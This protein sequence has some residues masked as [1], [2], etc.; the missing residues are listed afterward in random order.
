MSATG[1]SNLTDNTATGDETLTGGIQYEQPNDNGILVKKDDGLS[2]LYKS[3]DHLFFNNQ[4]LTG[5]AASAANSV[6]FDTDSNNPYSI[7]D[8][9]DGERLTQVKF[10]DQTTKGNITFS[11]DSFNFDKNIISPNVDATNKTDIAGKVNKSG[12]TMSGTLD[13]DSNPIKLGFTST[14]N[15]YNPVLYIGDND[16]SSHPY[17]EYNGSSGGLL[18]LVLGGN[19]GYFAVRS[20]SGASNDILRAD[21]NTITTNKPLIATDEIVMNGN[22]IELSN[23]NN[24]T[25]EYSNPTLNVSV[26]GN[27]HNISLNGPSQAGAI[28]I[29]NT[30]TDINQDINITNGSSILFDGEGSIS[31][32]D[33]NNTLSL[34]A[35]DT[36]GN[37]E[38]LADAQRMTYNGDNLISSNDAVFNSDVI[39]NNNALDFSNA[40]GLND[41]L[42]FK[43][44]SNLSFNSDLDRYFYLIDSNGNNGDSAYSIRRGIGGGSTKSILTIDKPTTTTDRLK[45]D[46][47]NLEF[48]QNSFTLGGETITAGATRL[49]YKSQDL[50]FLSDVSGGTTTTAEAYNVSQPINSTN[51][52][53][54]TAGCIW[55]GRPVQLSADGTTANTLNLRVYDDMELSGFTDYDFSCANVASGNYIF[56]NL[57]FHRAFDVCEIPNANIL[58]CAGSI[59]DNVGSGENRICINY[60]S[61]DPDL[62]SYAF[63][64][65]TPTTYTANS[66]GESAIARELALS[67]SHTYIQ[68]SGAGA[69]HVVYTATASQFYSSG[70]GNCRIMP[71]FIPVGKANDITVSSLST[72]LSSFASPYNDGNNQYTTLSMCSLPENGGCLLA[73]VNNDSGIYNRI[74]YLSSVLNSNNSYIH[75]GNSGVIYEQNILS[76]ENPNSPSGNI[77]TCSI[78]IK[79]HYDPATDDNVGIGECDIIFGYTWNAIACYSV[80]NFKF[81]KKTSFTLSNPIKRFY[82]SINVDCETISPNN[83]YVLNYMPT[84]VSSFESGQSLVGYLESLDLY[85]HICKAGGSTNG[86]GDFPVIQFFSASTGRR[87]NVKSIENTSKLIGYNG[88]VN[89]YN[90]AIMTNQMFCHTYKDNIVVF[91]Q[92]SSDEIKT[93]SLTNL[94]YA[95]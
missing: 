22:P 76:I 15:Q 14:T 90:S 87:I 46:T 8:E 16:T 28:N 65:S 50:A 61:F 26:N 1:N 89:T 95:F 82:G 62:N 29:K 36:A 88:L 34:S 13:M 11:S 41:V 27:S 71:I 10:D 31:Y 80:M 68:S 37:I 55:N 73:V 83:D 58:V 43:N 52:Q 20:E 54:M 38:F 67:Y 64:Q 49:N 57:P 23:T 81:N 66:I 59:K 32:N 51:N 7:P 86:Y 53:Y 6:H 74:Y 5:P 35:L 93:W 91:C 9:T 30:T 75:S 39:M 12:D 17:L 92:S 70:S 84:L 2:K 25:I 33:T 77:R 45:L 56:L 85:F 40:T 72:P 24:A 18:G 63:I 4:A 19:D 94:K 3:G 42:V 47:D 79:P 60:F 21:K 48:T 44:G 69:Q 78:D